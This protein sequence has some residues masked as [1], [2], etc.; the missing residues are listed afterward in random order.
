MI[1]FICLGETGMKRLGFNSVVFFIQVEKWCIV[2]VGLIV[3]LLQTRV[4][5][6]RI[7]N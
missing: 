4:T 5:W 2:V 1:F 3:N 6:E 7:S